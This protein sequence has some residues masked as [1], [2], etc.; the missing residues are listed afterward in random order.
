VPSALIDTLLGL[1]VL[2][3]VGSQVWSRKWQAKRAARMAAAGASSGEAG[4]A[5]AAGGESETSAPPARPS[6][7]IQTSSIT[8]GRSAAEE[9]G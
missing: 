6:P 1:V 8:R 7:V 3:V 9:V 5:S 4:G 2:F